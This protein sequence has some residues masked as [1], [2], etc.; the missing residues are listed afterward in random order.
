MRGRAPVER[1]LVVAGLVLCWSFGQNSAS[2]SL[3][4]D[5]WLTKHHEKGYCATYGVGG[6]RKDKD[7][8]AAANNTQAQPVSPQF[9]Q[10]L[11]AVCPQ[12]AGEVGGASG[13]YCC[14]EEQI[15]RLEAQVQIAKT[16]TIG[17]PACSHNFKHFFCLLTCSP[18]QASFTNVTAV[19]QAAD[20]NATVVKEVDYFIADS[21]GA[22]FFN[23][24]KDVVYAPTNQKAMQFLGGGAKNFT[25]W[26]AFLGLVKDK[27]FPP[28]GSPFQLNFPGEAAT[29]AGMTPMNKSVPPCWDPALRCSCGD[30]PDGPTCIPPPPAPPPKGSG[31]TALGL[32][33]TS[34]SCLDF[35]LL[36]VY[37]ALLL[38]GL[39]LLLMHLRGRLHASKLSAALRHLLSEQR[40]PQ[41]DAQ[42][43]AALLDEGALD[44]PS[45]AAE[46]DNESVADG[47]EA[48][49][50]ARYSGWERHMRDWFSWQGRVCAEQPW[51]VL[52]LC[53]LLVGLCAL[54]LLRFRVE[55]NPQKLWVGPGSQAAQEKQMY[56]ASFGPFYRIE[57]LIVSTRTDTP[58]AYLS[59]SGLPSIVSDANIKLMFA[60]QAA[61]DGLSVTVPGEDPDSPVQNVTLTSVCYKPM[62]DACATQSILQYWQM[63]E[64]FYTKGFPPYATKLSPDF[65]FSHWST[66]C[67]SA[68]QAPMDPHLVL[69]GFPAGPEFRNYTADATAFVVTYPVDSSEHKRAAALAWEAAFLRLAQDTLRPMAQA[70]RLDLSFST[71][72]SV[73]DELA[74][75][76]YTDAGTVAISYLVMLAYIAVALG[77]LPRGG[78]PLQLLVYSRLSLGLGGVLMVAAAVLGALGVCSLLGVWATLIIME[79]IPFLVLAVGVDNMFILAHALQREDPQRPLPERMSAALAA[80]GP[81]ISLAAACEVVAFGLGALTPMP[82]V[83][84]FS[85]VAAVAVLLDYLLQVTAFVA[86]LALDTQRTEQGRLDIAPCIQLTPEQ[87]ATNHTKDARPRDGDRHDMGY[88]SD[89]GSERDSEGSQ[90]LGDPASKEPISITS[91]LKWYMANVH[92]PLLQRPAMQVGVLAVFCGAF[93]LSLA[94]LPHLSRGLAQQ[95]AL[96]RDSY[97][98]PY[99]EDVMGYLRVG[100]PLMFVVK[101]L[102]MSADAPDVNA[103]CSVAGCSDTSFLNQVGNQARIPQQSYIAAPAAS[104]L[105]DFL[106]WIS[107]DLPQCC[108]TFPDARRCPPPDQPPCNST[109]SPPPCAACQACF[110]A[111]GP[112]GP[113]LLVDGRPSVEQVKQRLPWFMEALPS[114]ECAKGGAA[115]YDNAL[116]PSAHAASG[117]AGL[118]DGLVRASYFRTYYTPLGKDADFVNGLQAVREFVARVR[119]DLG[120]D[121]Y[122]YS[123]W[124]IFFEQYL[125]IAHDAV[126]LLCGAGIAVGLVCLAFT[127]SLWASG[128][129]LAMLAMILVDLEGCMVLMGIQLNAVSLVNLVMALGISV[130]FCAHIMHSFMVLPG[131]RPQRA[132]QALQDMGASVLSG[133]T[134]TKFA[135]VTVLAFARTQIFEVYYFRM[136]LALVL[137]GAAHGL[138]LLPVVLSLA[139][140]PPLAADLEEVEAG[141][142]SLAGPPLDE[143]MDED[144]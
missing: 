6:H 141:L 67:R 83:R 93:L 134:L 107:P 116:Q 100:P 124:H 78:G 14:T 132:S 136:Y 135:G 72:R 25:E 55:T 73:E 35:G 84:N 22:A 32:A 48:Q 111:A 138:I 2:S 129:I 34:L 85:L 8:L 92:A 11:Q 105:D 86:L 49:G 74:R 4:A 33:P 21:F 70:A 24:C 128:I 81:S 7:V 96:P 117:I 143:E 75:E 87:V 133:I 68:F 57:Q 106:A 9:A 59:P 18:D 23:S 108:R 37:L 109:A 82:A 80:A 140:P 26:F 119:T 28:T 19:Q 99:F 16:F 69:G 113:D 5:D 44:A 20:N 139:G 123:I 27:R 12:L 61:V 29:P 3:R 13:H 52:L 77:S 64:A 53:L 142:T 39:P 101:D 62:G 38:V 102:D 127:A 10:K 144:I 97:L 115:V 66:Q 103:V 112:P 104:W 130:E 118:D 137:L 15:D 51:Q 94:A 122:A 114:E 54:G 89:Y 36:A 58:A 46:T 95:V 110:R 120:L 121:V 30:C 47:A 31:C 79:V 91:G 45:K 65:C 60:M 76:T 17:C 40:Q 56:E 88:G 1:Y 41:E 63:E 98:Q 42:A 50:R 131:P 43:Q 125:H 90:E 71:E 126:V